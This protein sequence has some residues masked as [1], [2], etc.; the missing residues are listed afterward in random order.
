[1]MDLGFGSETWVPHSTSNAQDK[2]YQ[3]IELGVW[4]PWL[5]IMVATNLELWVER[6]GFGTDLDV[7]D[8]WNLILIGIYGRILLIP[9]ELS[10]KEPA[11]HAAMI[12]PLRLRYELLPMNQI[13]Y[14]GCT[15]WAQ[16][17]VQ[18][19]RIFFGNRSWNFARP[20][21][22]AKAEGW[23][24]LWIVPAQHI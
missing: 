6:G 3:A 21:N 7:N 23:G 20:Q 1:M 18:D 17:S 2:P 4:C 9:G 8:E 24:W 10:Y 11:D 19:S 5:A 14:C 13:G 12:S 15:T 16:G 22:M